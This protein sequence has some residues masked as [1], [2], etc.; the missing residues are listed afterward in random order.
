[1]SWF[2]ILAIA[3]GLAMDAA[4]VS[5]SA[6]ATGRVRGKRAAFRL[7]FHFGLFQ[8]LMPFVGWFLGNALVDVVGAWDHWLA[9][10]LLVIVGGRMIRG[11]LDSN[12]DP[13]DRGD[14]SSG[15]YLVALS[16]ATSIDALAVGLG[17][18]LLAVPLWIPCL[19]IG[20]VT[21]ALSLTAFRLGQVLG[22]RLGS[23][24]EIA[25]GMML[26]AIGVYIVV[27]HLQG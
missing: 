12:R 7:S 21:A 11:G 26:M 27:T 3:V 23:R 22:A 6:G 24:M 2:A 1:M 9:L 17:L 18:G 20:L 10:A 16:V 25:G 19:V 5:L 8:F 13:S 15:W 14:P 4:A